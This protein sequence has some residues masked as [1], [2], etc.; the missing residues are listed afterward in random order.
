MT[1]EM[2]TRLSDDERATLGAAWSADRGWEFLTELIEI[3]NR[4]GGH[5]GEQRAAE[6]VA[7]CLRDAGARDVTVDSFPMTRWNRGT[8]ELSVTAPVDRGFEA[9]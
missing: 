9:G 7:E 1:S 6:L 4:M 3:S 2:Q 5:P 8:T